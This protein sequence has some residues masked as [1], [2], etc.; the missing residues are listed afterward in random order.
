MEPMSWKEQQVSRDRKDRSLQPRP[1]SEQGRKEVVSSRVKS[2]FYFESIVLVC[3][4]VPG[5]LLLLASFPGNLFVSYCQCLHEYV[6]QG[7]NGDS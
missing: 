7:G 6:T 2:V 3:P 1:F 5:V 4:A